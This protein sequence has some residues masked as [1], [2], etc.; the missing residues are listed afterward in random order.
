[1][2]IQ[3]VPLPAVS[4]GTVLVQNHYSLIS[5]GTEGSTVKA[6]RKGLIGKAR[7]RPQQVKQVFDVLKQQG[8]AQTYRAVMKKLDAYSPLGY[9]SAGVVID[10]GKGV[11]N[12]SVGDKVACA[13]AGYA[14]HAEIISVPE[15]LCVRLRQDSDLQLACYNTLG[16]IALQGIRQ[17]DLRLGETCAVIGLGLIGQLACLML[18]ASGVRVFGIDI[19]RAAAETA[20]KH[21]CD[22][23]FLRTGHAVEEEIHRLTR[24]MGV[25]AVII[26][27]ASS[28]HDPINLA[29]AVARKKGKVVIVG[30]V[31]TGFDREPHYYKK[32]LDLRMS[33]SYGPGR[34][35]PLYE[36]HGLDYPP[37]YV[38]WTENRNMEA[39]Q[40]LI[41]GGRIDL[42]YLTTHVFKFADAP[43]A[44]DMMME[45]S[46]PFM[47]ILIAYDIG[48]TIKR[49]RIEIKGHDRGP[50]SSVNIGF[51]GAGSYAQSQLLPNIPK[52]AGVS[53]KGI[54]TATG[55]GARSVAER[56]GFDFCTD[57][58]SEIIENDAINTVFIA[59]RHNT[60]ADFVQ[61]S[62][63]AGK[64]VFVEKPLCLH[65]GELNEIEN[66]YKALSKKQ[67]DKAAGG[68]TPLLMVGYNRRFSPLGREI[69]NNF[70]GGPLA[71]VYR[72][73]AGHIPKDSWIQ[74]IEIG[75][76]RIIGEVCHFVDFLTFLNGSLPVSVSAQA[77]EDVNHLND[78]LVVSLKYENGSIGTI[79]YFANGDKA[80][81][82][83]RVEVFANGCTAVL[84]D[85][86][87][88]DIYA[89]G[90]KKTKKYLSQDKG[91]KAEVSQFIDAVKNGKPSP[92]P[93]H[94]IFSASRVCFSILESIRTGQT[95]V[96][97]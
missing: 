13:G 55:T 68:Q 94:Q 56:F 26:T 91:Q 77:M 25:D 47:G 36:E 67:A 65:E 79:C 54:L 4:A 33:C 86:K 64:N 90:K 19:D 11:K 87:R 39:F 48:K 73:N 32:E 92:I 61:K 40:D 2:T 15:N 5:A 53:L 8:P 37:A 31:P 51:I 75:G 16:A 60:H 97:S 21:C 93:I 14:N 84:D 71:M 78:V 35:D 52:N 17:A 63:K 46:E 72:V 69:K 96:N 28:S 10:V 9:S 27:A 81:C 50:V 44:Y 95:I 42:S 41:A 80:L 49:G 1:M 85:F 57:L 59:T 89:G 24:G 62:L 74:D 12:I 88:L 58:E 20:R 43:R 30:D 22:A 34:Y 70:P 6:A 45:R 23:A 3:E 82:K 76:G 38:R 7:E 18:K 83:E 66:L 29:G